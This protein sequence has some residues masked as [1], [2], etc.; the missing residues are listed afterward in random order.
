MITIDEF[1]D[2]LGELAQELPEAF[3]RE[4]N[5]GVNLLDRAKPSPAGRGNDLFILGEYERSH[6]MGRSIYIYYGSFMRI[7]PNLDV[8]ELT[9]QIR[10]TLRHEFRHHM[11]SLAGCRDLELEDEEFLEKY[12]SSGEDR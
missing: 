12:L 2:I 6:L 3:F 9:V 10:K 7:Y 11:E 1:Q 8:E 4:L 5:G